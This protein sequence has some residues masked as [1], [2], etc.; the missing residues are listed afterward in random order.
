M[1]PYPGDPLPPGVGATKSAKRLAVSEA[2][3]ITKIPVLPI[4]Y[5]DAQ[6]LLAA[7]GGRVAPPDWRGGLA[8]TYHIGPG[9]ARAHFH[10]KPDGGLKTLNRGIGRIPGRPA[11]E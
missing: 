3:T 6:P 9:P 4:S 11:P 2:P 8:I 1:T 10:I 5:G 7:L